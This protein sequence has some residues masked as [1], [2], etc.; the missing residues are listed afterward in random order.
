MIRNRKKAAPVL[1]AALLLSPVLAA[2]GGGEGEGE[3]AG[4][5]P[6]SSAKPH[7]Y[8][9]GAEETAEQQSR[10]VLSDAESGK[11]ELLDLIKGKTTALGRTDK[12]A[13]LRTD[14]RFAYAREGGGAKVFDSGS[15]MVDHGDHIHY[16]RAAARELGDIAGKKP[17]HVYSS[18]S[19]TAVTFGDGTAKVLDHARMEKGK[20]RKTATFDD[21]RKGP[22]VPYEGNALVPVSGPGGSTVIE[23]RDKRGRT[24]TTLKEKCRDLRGA[25]VTRRGVVFGCADG[26][27]FVKSASGKPAAEKIAFGRKVAADERPESFQHR[28][29]STTLTAKAGDKGVWILDVADRRWKLIETGPVIAANT[30]GE[31]APL[32]ALDRSG[33]LKSYEISDGKEIA[34]KK[35]LK[36][37]PGKKE[38]DRTVVEIDANRAYVNDIGAR[39]VYEIDYN[40]DLRKARSFALDFTPSHMVETGR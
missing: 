9:E 31:G 8:V 23:A 27:L 14:G 3:S 32:V 7:G 26:A 11:V 12:A 24:K 35:I 20:L 4:A 5:K 38:G 40:D 13:T 33:T 30:A 22:V 10:L 17:E 2:C 25:A 28:S 16:Y 6:K 19:L 34:S 39:K 21:V 36:D 1:V 29:Q 18:T 15:W 37:P